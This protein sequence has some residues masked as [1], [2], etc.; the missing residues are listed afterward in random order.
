MQTELEE[1]AGS[2][3]ANDK[4]AKDDLV[5]RLEKLELQK[6]KWKIELAELKGAISILESKKYPLLERA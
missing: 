6:S 5:L 3:K 4:K 1:L 2:I